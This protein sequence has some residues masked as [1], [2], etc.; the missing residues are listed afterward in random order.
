MSSLASEDWAWRMT[1]FT[2]P[3]QSQLTAGIV[4]DI[5]SDGSCGLTRFDVSM[6]LHLP[7]LECFIDNYDDME[8]TCP[9]T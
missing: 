6:Q 4:E 9:V 7:L 5:V 8:N 3:Y 1:H 2:I